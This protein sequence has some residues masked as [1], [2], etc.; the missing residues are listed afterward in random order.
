MGVRTK[1]L[2]GLLKDARTRTIIIITAVLILFAAIAGYYVFQARVGGPGGKASLAEAPGAIESTPG[3]FNPSAE[4]VKLQEKQNQENAEQALKTGGSAIPTIIG[5]TKVGPGTAVQGGG[6]GFKELAQQGENLSPKS[7]S[8]QQV[9]QTACSLDSIKKAQQLGASPADLKEA[10]CDADQLRAAGYGTDALQQAG[11][12]ACDLLTDTKLSPL[13]LKKAGYSAG[14]L[15]GVGFNA[16]QLKKAGYNA[17]QLAQAGFAP[18]EL[19]GVGFSPDQIASA[20]LKTG[21]GVISGPLPP[22]VTLASLKAKGCSPAAIQQ[23]YAQG[24]SAAALREIGCTAAEIKAGGY[25]AADLKNAGFTAGELLQAGFTPAQLKQAGFTA[26]QLAAAGVTPDQLKQAGY[27]SAEIAQAQQAIQAMGLPPGVTPASLKQAGCSAAAV[28]KAKAMGVSASV[29]RQIGCTAAQLKAGG[30]SAA[31][32]ENAGYTLGELIKA[33]FSPADLAKAGFTAQQL[34]D[35]GFTA[36]QL[37]AAGFSAS[38]L[39]DAGFSPKELA[40]AGFSADQL[41]NAGFSEADLQ[42]AGVITPPLPSTTGA[43]QTQQ[44]TE[45]DAALAQSQALLKSQQLQQ[46]Q[47]Q[48]TSTM[49]A[50]A[51]QLFSAWKAA[52]QSY[53]EGEPPKES[54]EGGGSGGNGAPGSG[55]GAQ[56]GGKTNQKVAV[57]AGTIM[58]AVLDTAI[59][60]DE[61]GPV[62]AT[63]VQG[64]F[65]GAT[66]LGQMTTFPPKGQAVMLTFNV[67]NMPGASKSVSVNA[68]AI[69]A[70]TART[71]L[72]SK[73]NN[74]YFLR[75]GSLFAA[76]FLQGYG[77]AF[78]QSGQQIAVGPT[79]TVSSTP[80]LSPTGKLMVALGNVGNQFGTVLQSVYTTPPTVQI[81]SGTGVG[82]LFMADVPELS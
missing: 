40:D 41:K 66:L 23:A 17:S 54:G 8:L 43:Q 39:K 48:T 12:S 53:V 46:L 47:T 58:Y 80:N 2:A 31:D 14:E 38:E 45:E 76:S 75:F 6:V 19:K 28:A 49:A 73:V 11:F 50:Q 62:L 34:K 7:L 30:Y 78:L 16:C 82:I 64:K 1:N 68:V 63:I 29:M 74:H 4:Y 22:G 35:A 33:G 52:T 13:A 65:A 25:T 71:A 18:D 44:T 77:Q 70:E 5:A 51:G 59:N 60:S 21:A 26:G 72:A 56:Q 10:G 24:V 61:P 36:A 3:G 57:Q 27:T 37:K 81:Y 32:L 67:M 55:N 42:S 69:D 9:R 15:K 20:G 79:V